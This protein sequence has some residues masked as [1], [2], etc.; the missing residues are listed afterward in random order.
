MTSKLVVNTIESDTG[1]S[2]VSFASSISMS[3]TS[4]FHFSA[5]GIDIGADTNIN[6]PSAGVLGFNI[7]GSQKVSIGSEGLLTVTTTGQNRGIKL[8]DSSLSSGSPNLEII[9][10]RQD[11][12]VN[13]AFSS[14]IFLG[15][16]RT[17]QKVANNKFLGTVNFGGN[18]TDGTEGNISYSAAIAARASGDFNSK[19]DMPTDLIFTTG[20]SGTDR[21]GETAGQ[22]N[23]G[24]ER[25]RIT[26]DGKIGI[27]NDNPSYPLVL[28][29]TNNTTYS[30]SNFIA[31]GLQIENDSTTD[32]TASGIFFTAKGSGANAGAAH[33]N[34]IRTANGSG[35]LAFSTRHNVGSHVERF[36]IT[37]NGRINIGDADQT[38]DVD[39]FSV[40][41]AAPN[42]LDNVARFQ[43]NAAASGTSET[44][45]K[46]YKGAGYGGVVSGYITQG[47]DHGLK[48]YTANNGTLSEGLRATSNGII[49]APTQAG[50]YARMQNTKT[51]VMGGGAAYYTIPF[52]TDSGSICYDTHNSYNTSNG[53]YTVPTHGTGHYIVSTAVCLSTSVY[54]RGGECWF[55]VGSNR[56]FFDRKYFASTG[57]TITGFYG[58]INIKLTAGQTIGVQGFISGGSQNVD[59]Q[60]ANA[61]DQI[62]WFTARKIA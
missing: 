15:S 23:V 34:C 61:T 44:L 28:T 27:G 48:L 46:I 37:S 56:Y 58:T 8:V 2:S 49:D 4:K 9:S 14:N 24:T 1:I 54:G 55:L 16:N 5:A 51:S 6:R 43:S 32:N 25:L 35:S 39:Q 41:V 11:A 57:G 18:H 52:D 60:G 10:K 13:T 50:F 33:I 17:D 12:N 29:Y 30:S 7:N 47:S 53:L 40:T 22:S 31:N 19:S 20:T 38:Q 21:D 62:T 59:V 3:S 26:S 36:R 42:V 45:V